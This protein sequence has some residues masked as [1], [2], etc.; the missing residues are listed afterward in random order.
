MTLTFNSD[1]YKELLTKYQPRL[2]RNEEENEKALAIVE[3]LMHRRN[4]TPEED[5][6][7]DLLITLIE[8]FEQEYYAPGQSSTPHSMLVFLMEQKDI[9]Q[10]DLVRVISSEVVNGKREIS[11]VEAKALGDFF[12]VDADL[13]V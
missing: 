5:E 11:K 3:K 4:L 13:F 1:K 6:L 7:F 10:S 9:K 8:K 2:I 12:K